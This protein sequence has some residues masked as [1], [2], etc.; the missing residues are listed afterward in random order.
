MTQ[1][2][3]YEAARHALQEARA[4]DEVKDIK[5]KAE[6]LRLYARQ[7]NDRDMEVWTS[8]IKV[9]AVRRMGELSSSID[10]GRGAN[11]YQ[12]RPDVRT[13]LDILA[14][15][16]IARSTAHEYEQVAAIPE[17][18]FEQ[19]IAEARETQQPATVIGLLKPHVAQNS[20]NNEWYTPPDIIAAARKA[21]GS[22]DVDP[23][24]SVVANRTVE[25]ERFYT[26]EMDG[27]LADWI[28][29][30]WLN[31]PYSNPE[32][33]QFCEKLLAE[34]KCKNVVQACLLVNN[35]TETGWFQPTFQRAAAVCFPKGRLRYLDATGK[36]ANTPLQ[37]QAILYFG[38]SPLVFA[39]SFA[40]LG[41]TMVRR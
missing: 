34:I 13:K 24:S 21:M 33:G 39:K 14:D 6:A 11:Q 16:G 15:A 8:E 30:V 28:G 4:V 23:A 22:I 32:I 1:L 20:G 5:D 41:E 36:P 27:L 9:R 29:N 2:V 12:E 10:H 38:G 19:K 31:P 17:A 7:A 40:K 18:E 25:A 37:G 26:I 35:A 3:R